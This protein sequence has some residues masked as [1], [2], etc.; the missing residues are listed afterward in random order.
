MDQSQTSDIRQSMY[1]GD[2]RDLRV[3]WYEMFHKLKIAIYKIKGATGKFRASR[4]TK[5]TKISDATVPL[6]EN[7][8]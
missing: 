3:F 2:S 8:L 7:I 5:D 6:R 1:L 4:G